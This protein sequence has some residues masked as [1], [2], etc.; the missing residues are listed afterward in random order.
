M[1]ILGIDPGWQTGLA[2]LDGMSMV[3]GLVRGEVLS[4]PDDCQAEERRDRLA[5]LLGVALREIRPDYVVIEAPR[6]DASMWGRGSGRT[7]PEAIAES[8]A[9]ARDTHHLWQ[10]CVR[11][12]ETAGRQGVPVIWQTAAA[13]KQALGATGGSDRR[14]VEW[15]NRLLRPEPPLLVKHHHIARAAGVAL[16]ARGDVRLA[17]AAGAGV[18]ADAH[19]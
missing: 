12:A 14:V 2:L 18:E 17:R 11:F 3:R 1:T 4:A 8:R 9:K 7:T 13:G 15:C 6:V 10:L 16:R 5:M 19:D